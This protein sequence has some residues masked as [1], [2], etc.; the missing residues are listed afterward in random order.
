MVAE[1]AWAWAQQGMGWVARAYMERGR[2]ARVCKGAGLGCACGMRCTQMSVPGLLRRPHCA[3]RR[4]LFGGGVR[5]SGRLD[6]SPLTEAVLRDTV[7]R[8]VGVA[9]LDAARQEAEVAARA[10]GMGLRLGNE[11]EGAATGLGGRGP[12]RGE[13]EQQEQGK[14]QDQEQE[15][16]SRGGAGFPHD[17]DWD[18]RVMVEAMRVFRP[19]EL[20]VVDGLLP[21]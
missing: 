12:L 7:P 16:V 3:L 15:Q 19:Q 20:G 4:E 2:V 6:V 10:L 11:V 17:P 21:I 8:T 18:P 14:L 13:V 1:A 5:Q 9:L